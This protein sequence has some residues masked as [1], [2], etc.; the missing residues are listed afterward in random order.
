MGDAK[1]SSQPPLLEGFICHFF[2]GEITAWCRGAFSAWGFINLG[3]VNFVSWS[4]KCLLQ[5]ILESDPRV[6]S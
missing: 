4:P 5:Q 2:Q 3:L 6:K 1:L